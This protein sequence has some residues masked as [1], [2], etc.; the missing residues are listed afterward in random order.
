MEGLWK[1]YIRWKREQKKGRQNIKKEWKREK[2]EA[3]IKGERNLEMENKENKLKGCVGV[4]GEV[5]KR[6]RI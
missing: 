2:G 1:R 3:D 6:K 5:G 4:E